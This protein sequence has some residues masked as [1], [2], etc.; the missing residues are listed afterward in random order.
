MER[1]KVRRNQKAF[2]DNLADI[3][4]KQVAELNRNRIDVRLQL[5]AVETYAMP[6]AMT[7]LTLGDVAAMKGNI[8][9]L[10]KKCND[11]HFCFK[12]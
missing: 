12:V 1:I 3:L 10:F 8:S 7:C 2:H 11:R 5:R 9:P 6:E 4:H